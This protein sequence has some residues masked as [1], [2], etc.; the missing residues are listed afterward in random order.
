MTQGDKSKAQ[1]VPNMNECQ[2]GNN[3]KNPAIPMMPSM[4]KYVIAKILAAVVLDVQ[5][6]V[7]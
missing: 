6:Q 3:C 5:Q 4:T 7:Q 1:Q 2:I